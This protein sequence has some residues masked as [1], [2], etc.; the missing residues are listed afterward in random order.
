MRSQAI[1]NSRN[2]IIQ[3]NKRVTNIKTKEF[4]NC[5]FTDLVKS[6]TVR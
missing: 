6:V 3:S 1:K 4:V 5:C 2:N